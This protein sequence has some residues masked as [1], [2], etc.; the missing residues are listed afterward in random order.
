MKILICSCNRRLQAILLNSI[1]LFKALT[2]ISFNFFDYMVM[3]SL[4]AL[5][6]LPAIGYKYYIN[7]SYF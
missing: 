3:L 7:V 4:N 2:R 1:H 5:R 6:L